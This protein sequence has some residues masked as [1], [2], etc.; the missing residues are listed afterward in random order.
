MF[1]PMSNAMQELKETMARLRS[2]GGC[3]WDLEQDH[4][5]IARCLIEECAELLETIDRGD[6]EHMREELGDVLLQV[7]FHARMAEEA[8]HFA[9]DD[10]AAEINNKLIRRHPHVFGDSK[11]SNAEDVLEQ[12]E[13]IKSGEKNRPGPNGFFKELP[14]VLPALLRA[15][16]MAKQVEKKGMVEEILPNADK[17]KDLAKH[18]TEEK[19]G[20][21]L[22]TLAAACRLAG[23]DPE[24]ALRRRT[25]RLIEDTETRMA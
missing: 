18:L 22:F 17:I 7:V 11:A 15:W 23:I 6:M 2:P 5:S 12:W 16:E 14:A 9:F 4:R 8:G 13:K 10:V 24:S 1:D 3:P 19:A 21:Q 20:E 25:A